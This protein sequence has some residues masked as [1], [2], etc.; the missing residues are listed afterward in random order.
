MRKSRSSRSRDFDRRVTAPLR[1]ASSHRLLRLAFFL[2][3]RMSAVAG[4]VTVQQLLGS[5]Q[6]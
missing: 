6:C 2:K 5:T 3:S 1:C 4:P